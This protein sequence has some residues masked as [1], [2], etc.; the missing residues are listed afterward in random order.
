M[1]GHTEMVLYLSQRNNTN[2]IEGNVTMFGETIEINGHRVSHVTFDEN[3][4]IN[5][6]RADKYGDYLRIYY[7]SGDKIVNNYLTLWLQDDML[8][9]TSLNGDGAYTEAGGQSSS[10]CSEGV[11]YAGT[12]RLSDASTLNQ[13]TLKLKPVPDVYLPADSTGQ[14]ITLEAN[15]S[16]ATP[17]EYNAT[18]MD[19]YVV[20]VD[21]IVDNNISL[22]PASELE[23]S[24]TVTVSV[25]THGMRAEGNI[26]VYIVPDGDNNATDANTSTEDTNTP[27]DNN[28][29]AIGGGCTYNPHSKGFDLIMFL[30]L[31]GS[32]LYPF[33]HRLVGR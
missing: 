4:E 14:T 32:L 7:E 24:T 6:S 12:I 3:G 17:L 10:G 23:A 22:I 5:S 11:G 18:S 30:M 16:V 2:L 1:S 31:L 21:E 19:P 29:S 26:T 33:R 20:V 13:A 25:A 8:V 28:N 27:E 9:G 15:C